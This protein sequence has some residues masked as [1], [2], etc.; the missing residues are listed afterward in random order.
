MV[1]G[2]GTSGVFDFYLT[3][4]TVDYQGCHGQTR[5][6]SIR[7]AALFNW[8]YAIACSNAE[9]WHCSM[10]R[11]DKLHDCV[12]Y[13]RD[14]QSSCTLDPGLC[15]GITGYFTQLFN[16][17]TASLYYLDSGMISRHRFR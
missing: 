3:V 5:S 15:S 13:N 11:R 10:C 16:T 8:L 7:I 17:N 9:D 14:P 12:Y 4:T 1:W 2:S 6:T